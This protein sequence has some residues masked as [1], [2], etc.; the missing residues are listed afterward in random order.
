MPRA[1]R[2]PPVGGAPRPA[3]SAATKKTALLLIDFLNEFAFPGGTRLAARALPAAEATAALRQR[4]RA[5]SQPVIYVNDNMWRWRSDFA[6]IY[7]R[8]ADAR[9]RGRKVAAMLPPDEQ[10][11][12]VL[13]PKNS[14]FYDSPLDSLLDYLQVR[15]LILAGLSV[16]SCVLFTANDAHLREYE[17]VVAE[18]CVAGMNLASERRALEYFRQVLEADV[19]A[20]AAIRL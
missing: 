5:K 17:L 19:R 7:A 2:A 15:R 20:S 3:R 16:E 12:F 1:R 13:K 11:H 14:A 8:C 10:D 18:D 6:H 4:M 9:S